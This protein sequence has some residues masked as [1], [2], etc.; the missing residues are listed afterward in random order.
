MNN[1]SIYILNIYHYSIMIRDTLEYTMDK[2]SY[3]YESY[4]MRKDLILRGIQPNTPLGSFLEKNNTDEKHLGDDIK[5]KIQTFHDEIYGDDSTIIKVTPEKELRVDKSQHMAIYNY[6]IG[7][8]ETMLDILYGYVN[9]AK[10]NNQLEPEIEKL[11]RTNDAFYRG[12]IYLQL[13]KDLFAQF[14]EFQVAMNE[15]KG[16]PTPQSNY[17]SQEIQKLYGFLGFIKNH[18][19]LTDEHTRDMF[20][21]V[22]RLLEMCSGKRDLPSGKKFPDVFNETIKHIAEYTRPNEIIWKDTYNPLYKEL[23]EQ[24]RKQAEKN[25]MMESE[26]HEDHSA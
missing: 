25:K 13:I 18:C 1:I 21:E 26:H 20:D 3:S 10:K 11:M 17:I 2:P 16:Q 5:N 24:A 15:S 6:V 4:L 8:Y 19:R 7:I 22:S 23:V 9:M 12:F 14:K